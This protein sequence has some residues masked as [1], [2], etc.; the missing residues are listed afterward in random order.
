M[1]TSQP[2][3]FI[4]LEEY[5]RQF[6]FQRMSA[7]PPA[8][9]AL[10]TS[11]DEAH[12]EIARLAALTYHAKYL[13]GERMMAAAEARPFSGAKI[14]DRG[15]LKKRGASEER[16]GRVKRRRAY[17]PV[18]SRSD[19]DSGAK[20]KRSRNHDTRGAR[21]NGARDV[22]DGPPRRE[23]YI[24]KD[25]VTAGASIAINGRGHHIH[26]NTGSGQQNVYHRNVGRDEERSSGRD[27]HSNETE[28]EEHSDSSSD[29]SSGDSTPAVYLEDRPRY[30]DARPAYAYYGGGAAYG[31][32]P[33]V[34]NDRGSDY[35]GPLYGGRW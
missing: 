26:I 3:N 22:D 35:C 14:R 12:A 15:R 31:G 24:R 4:S 27:E 13:E 21:R 32:L 28:R 2:L 25:D 1:S 11:Q 20:K 19:G 5:S 8:L 10:N 9:V 33:D 23:H 7:E 30:Q 6:P 29:S 17:L 16:G 18:S 34:S